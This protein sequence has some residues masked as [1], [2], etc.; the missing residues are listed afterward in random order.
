MYLLEEIETIFLLASSPQDT[1]IGFA[2]A[3]INLLLDVHC[4]DR[5]RKYS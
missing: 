4:S 5:E 3:S 2:E 1:S